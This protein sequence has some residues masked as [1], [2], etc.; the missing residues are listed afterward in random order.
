MDPEPRTSKRSAQLSRSKQAGL[1]GQR[2]EESPVS[3]GKAAHSCI[4]W[5]GWPKLGV[6][7]LWFGARYASC[8]SCNTDGPVHT[9]W[10]A[11]EQVSSPPENHLSPNIDLS[12]L[13]L[14]HRHCA[15]STHAASSSPI[16]TYVQASSMQVIHCS[17]QS[18]LPDTHLQAAKV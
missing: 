18:C 13:R 17:L 7:A 8:S 14:D 16:D 6:Q 15:Y 12:T 10:H 9:T 11:S 4:I 2:S 3:A 5:C 1:V